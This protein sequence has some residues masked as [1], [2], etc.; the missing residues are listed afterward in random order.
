MPQN[1]STMTAWPFQPDTPF[2]P[3][4]HRGGIGEAG[5]NTMQAFAA[6]MAAGYRYVET[7]VH[8]TRDGEI[9]AFHDS[10]LSRLTGHGARIGELDWPDIAGME[11][12]GGGNIPR[13]IDL[14]DAWPDLFVNIDPKSDAVV[15][16]LIELLRRQGAVRRVCVGSFSSARLRT[17]RKALGPELATSMG[18]GEI[19]RLR[20]AS[21]G[22]GRVPGG[23]ACVQVPVSY[24]GIRMVDARLIACAHEAGLKVHVWTVNDRPTMER[25]VDLGV[26]AIM[27]DD[28]ALLKSVLRSRG[29]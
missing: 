16:P 5:E 1:A 15:R 21:L 2:I 24:Y 4:A 18:P 26:D 17:I 20:L 23:V 25:L 27:T 14:L 8:L 11:I 13:L 29:L 9:V 7:D 6:A 12:A 22:L 3:I 28:L 19:L 10:D